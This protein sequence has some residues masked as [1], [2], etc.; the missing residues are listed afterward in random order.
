MSRF[1]HTRQPDWDWW[2]ELWPDPT[3]LLDRVGVLPG[4]L[5]VDVGCGNGYFTIPAAKLLEGPLYA[6][7]LDESLLAQLRAELD[8]RGIETVTCVRCDARSLSDH[9]PPVDVA[10]MANT[11][12]GVEDQTEF[13]TE[14]RR[15]L[16]REGRFIVVNWHDLPRSETVV[17]GKA[18]G[19]PEALRL[20]PAETT[21]AVVPA[22]FELVST[23]DVPPYHYALVFEREEKA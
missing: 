20:T 23:L 16:N 17:A 8:E 10:F 9:I 6:V 21:T 14:I 22:G 4:E 19:P 5:L 12:H 15:A 1:Q 2:S 18:R 11:F 3:G 13:A 7:D